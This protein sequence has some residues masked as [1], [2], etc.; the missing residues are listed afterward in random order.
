M[1]RSGAYLL[2]S[3]PGWKKTENNSKKQ[4]KTSEVPFTSLEYPW[5]WFFRAQACGSSKN[6]VKMLI[7]YYKKAS[8]LAMFFFLEGSLIIVVVVVVVVAGSSTISSTSTN[9]SETTYNEDET[10]LKQVMF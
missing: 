7:P 3:Q 5:D 9:E 1:D 6:T 2:S 8:P 4:E 10:C